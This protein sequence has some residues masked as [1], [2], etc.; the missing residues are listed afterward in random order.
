VTAVLASQVEIA[1]PTL[2]GGMLH[3]SFNTTAGLTYVV[4]ASDSLIPPDWE[5]LEE[6]AGDGGTKTYSD[7]TAEPHRFYRILIQ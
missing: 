2:S 7:P 3:L 4:Q 6:F 5:T 1:Q